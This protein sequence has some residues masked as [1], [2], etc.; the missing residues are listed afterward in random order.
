MH[1]IYYQIKG[2][3]IVAIQNS[4]SPKESMSLPP[5]D[6]L[7]EIDVD[8][9]EDSLTTRALRC[10]TCLELHGRTTEPA[11]AGTAQ[12]GAGTCPVLHH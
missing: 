4:I 12:T 1:D 7:S 5:S 2:D 9:G 8:I 11:S 10:D 3:R 6:I